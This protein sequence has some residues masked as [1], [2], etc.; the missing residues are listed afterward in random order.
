MGMGLTTYFYENQPIKLIIAGSRDF[1]DYK[2][3]KKEVAKFL[4]ELQV[5]VKPVIICGMARGADL[6]GKRL[7]DEFGFPVECMPADWNQFGKSAG[8]IRNKEMAK[9]ADA[10]ICFWNGSNGTKH[11]IDL[12]KQYKLKL[13]VVNFI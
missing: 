9:I 7:A 11:M 4:K 1:N 10:C 12:A 3:L 6:L 2:L 8:Y 5:E 13:R